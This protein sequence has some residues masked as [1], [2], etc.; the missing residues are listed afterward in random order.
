MRT[1]LNIDDEALTAIRKYAKER[2]ISLGEATSDLVHR[3]LETLP[4]FRMKNG[5]VIIDAPLVGAEEEAEQA[6][7]D[8]E[9]RRAI[10]I[11][12]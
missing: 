1:T 4:K 5:W 3:G 2:S 9:Y 7:Y 8:E 10:S 11:G 6:E 12:R